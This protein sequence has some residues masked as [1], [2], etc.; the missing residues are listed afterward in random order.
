MIT[1][2][3]SVTVTQKTLISCVQPVEMGMIYG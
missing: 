3:D 2:S 1:I